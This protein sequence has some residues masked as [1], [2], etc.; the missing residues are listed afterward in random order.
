MLYFPAAN[1]S[2]ALENIGT[3][4]A[5]DGALMLGAGKTVLGYVLEPGRRFMSDCFEILPEVRSLYRLVR[6][7]KRQILS[8][9]QA[10][11]LTLAENLGGIRAMI[12]PKFFPIACLILQRGIGR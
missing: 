10:R 1:H 3:A 11:P 5:A 9:D 8:A 12:R 6:D 4:L 2:K 7:E